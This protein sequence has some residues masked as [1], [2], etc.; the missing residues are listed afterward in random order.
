MKGEL[1]TDQVVLP[2][3]SDLHV[4]EV[5]R[6][7]GVVARALGVPRWLRRVPGGRQGRS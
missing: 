3:K 4:D 5:R 6:L 2:L 1:F 7:E